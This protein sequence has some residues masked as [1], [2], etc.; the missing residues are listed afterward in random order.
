MSDTA[1][2]SPCA[3]CSGDPYPLA[4][5]QR[6]FRQPRIDQ[7]QS[8]RRR[9]TNVGRFDIQVKLLLLMEVGQRLAGRLQ[10]GVIK[11]AGSVL[12]WSS[13]VCRSTPSI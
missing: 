2:T 3:C 5:G 8:A 4:M 9:Q 7:K 11:S 12:Y 6:Q 13:S 10:P 1:V